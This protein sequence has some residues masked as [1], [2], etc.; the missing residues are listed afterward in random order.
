MLC[1]C[2]VQHGHPE[3]RHGIGGEDAAVLAV[4]Q[5]I[6]KVQRAVEV[7]QEPRAPQKCLKLGE[8]GFL[9][10]GQECSGTARLESVVRSTWRADSSGHTLVL[11]FRAR[12]SRRRCWRGWR[13]LCGR[14]SC[15]VFPDLNERNFFFGS[16]APPACTHPRVLSSDPPK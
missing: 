9:G 13:C 4:T 8:E 3:N 2:L 14:D 6:A 5:D 7:L 12:Q 15:K 1:L 11:Y 16:I 10:Q